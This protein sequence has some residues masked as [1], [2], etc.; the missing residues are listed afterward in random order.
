VSISERT[1]DARL[2]AHADEPLD[3]E[4]IYRTH[5]NWLVAFLRRRFS[6]QDAE[7]LAQDAYVRALNGTVQIRNPRAFLARVAKR[8]ATDQIRQD[9][10]CGAAVAE[11]IHR[12]SLTRSP[13]DI[14]I[15]ALKQA[16][17]ALPP[18]L[19]E[20][21]VLS[22]F[23]GLTYAEIANRCGVSV[24]TVQERMGRAHAMCSALMRD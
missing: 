12:E 1:K 19:R 24:D 8:A 20:V 23:L 14:D 16:I 6:A 10:A 3:V 4:R 15:L 2:D 13:G 5:G 11:H 17:L 7:D 21:M 9:I 18:K 22:G